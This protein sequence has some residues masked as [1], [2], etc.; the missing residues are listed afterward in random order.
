MAT[1]NATPLRPL[2]VAAFLLSLLLGA[3]GGGG[4]GGDPEP[5]EGT[6]QAAAVPVTIDAY[7]DST[8][9]GDSRL[10]SAPA[11]AQAELGASYQVRNFGVGS[12]NTAKLLAGDGRNF[13]WA[14]QMAKTGATVVVINHGINDHP[15]PLETF[16][17]N[18][19]ELVYTAK[20]TG[21]RVILETPNPIVPEGAIAG[22]W[23][24]GTL[25]E[26]AEMVRKVAAGTGAYLCDQDRAMRDAGAATLEYMWDGVHPSTKGYEFKGRVLAGCIREALK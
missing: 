12:T 19:V 21:K 4:G 23:D 14:E 20:N 5:T 13:P 25:A 24:V 1:V 17:A 7:G 26:R 18:L 3:C 16:R 10:G 15:Y 8:Q 22:D 11:A 2:R 6:V 9:A